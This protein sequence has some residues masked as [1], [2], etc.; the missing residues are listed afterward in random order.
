M[1][2]QHRHE[3]YRIA[4]TTHNH[5]LIH[6]A[7]QQTIELRG[8]YGTYDEKEVRNKHDCHHC[9]HATPANLAVLCQNNI[10]QEAK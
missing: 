9:E 10:E 5:V 2:Y 7:D 4:I 6:P 3:R 1:E 8:I